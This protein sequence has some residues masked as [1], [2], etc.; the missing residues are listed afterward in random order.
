MAGNEHKKLKD[1]EFWYLRHGE[2]DWN[3]AGRL[4]G[5]SDI[6]LNETGVA[7][8]HAAGRELAKQFKDGAKPFSIIVSSP[9]DRAY[10]TAKIARDEIVAAGGPKLEIVTN[11]N[12][13]E[14]SFGVE[15]GN[16]LGTWYESWIN[17][18]EVPAEGESFE[19]LR[20]RAVKAI[21]S[22]DDQ[23]GVPLLVAHGALFRAIRSA[24]GLDINV[25]INNADPLRAI[26]PKDTDDDW[27]IFYP[28]H[29]ED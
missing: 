20:E 10:T 28:A 19:A 8:A 25:K 13:I 6:P 17:S 15:E 9:L 3:K 7:Q 22:L 24:M 23:K 5:R 11:P 4:Q 21:N 26:P 27:T 1:R 12:L 14:V 18:K 29:P 16:D 2:T